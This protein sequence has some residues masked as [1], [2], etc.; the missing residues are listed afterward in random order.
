MLHDRI[1]SGFDLEILLGAPCFLSLI[2]AGL[3]SVLGDDRAIDLAAH[4]SVTADDRWLA[5]LVSEVELHGGATRG[6]LTVKLRAGLGP[7]IIEAKTGNRAPAVATA[8]TPHKTVATKA[9]ADIQRPGPERVPAGP[10]LGRAVPTPTPQGP[11][12]RDAPARTPPAAPPLASTQLSLVLR[13]H[14][15]GDTIRVEPGVMARELATFSGWL[16]GQVGAMIALAAMGVIDRTLRAIEFTLPGLGRLPRVA[17]KW[18]AGDAATRPALALLVNLDLDL[19]SR[20]DGP[21]PAA[22]A[23]GDV[24]AAR[25]HLPPDVGVRVAASAATFSRLQTAAF[26]ACPSRFGTGDI[27]TA[28]LQKVELFLRPAQPGYVD[29]RI[30]LEVETPGLN[31]TLALQVPVVPRVAAGGLRWEVGPVARETDFHADLWMGVINTIIGTGKLFGVGG[32]WV[33]ELLDRGGELLGR[34]LAGALEPL[35]SALPA[36]LE[37][38]QAGATLALE[39]RAQAVAVDGAGASFHFAVQG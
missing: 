5:L 13:L 12:P 31:G 4:G 36:R 32:P 10:G 39:L 28:Y 38:R 20:A 37:V 23:R 7:S 33:G 27:G 18:L 2:R 11:A 9:P 19:R 22:S 3:R 35:A 25:S 34:K 8:P 29:I 1:D 15:Q 21:R 14:A 16:S 24:N 30:Q 6:D 26:W 17:W